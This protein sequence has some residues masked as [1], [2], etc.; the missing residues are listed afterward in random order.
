MKVRNNEGVNY[1]PIAFEATLV[2]KPVPNVTSAT[3]AV[4]A[5][6]GGK[7]EMNM[8]F[9]GMPTQDL[10]NDMLVATAAPIPILVNG[11]E[12][13]FKSRLAS[14]LCIGNS[15]IVIFF[16]YEYSELQAQRDCGT[17][18]PRSAEPMEHILTGRLAKKQS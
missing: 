14:L 12:T 7:T 15:A 2:P 11:L 18:A 6:N 10:R 17:N 3:G 9:K 1:L 13:A 4:T 5:N 8:I 16:E